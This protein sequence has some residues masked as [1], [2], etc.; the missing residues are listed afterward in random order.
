MKE[1]KGPR[2]IFSKLIE[3]GLT[4]YATPVLISW[5]SFP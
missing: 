2:V 1:T 3:K 4:D 5:R